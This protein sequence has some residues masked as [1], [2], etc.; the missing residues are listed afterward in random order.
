MKILWEQ[1][2]A[3]SPRICPLRIAMDPSIITWQDSS[4]TDPYMHLDI[5]F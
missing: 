4:D 1:W 2:S 5:N 3:G